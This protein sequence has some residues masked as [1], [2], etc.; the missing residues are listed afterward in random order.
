MHLIIHCYYYHYKIN[1]AYCHH[2]AIHYNISV[3]LHIVP[4]SLIKPQINDEMYTVEVG[5][6]LTLRCEASGSPTPIVL[7][8]KGVFESTWKTRTQDHG[9]ERAPRQERVF[10]PVTKE[11]AGLYVCLASN[12]LVGPPGGKRTV[13]D[14]KTMRVEVTG[15]FIIRIILKHWLDISF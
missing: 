8:L 7:L 6:R 9:E 12:I 1:F 13:T 2:N 4:A 11:D 5:G 10:D 15:M 3:W 14:W